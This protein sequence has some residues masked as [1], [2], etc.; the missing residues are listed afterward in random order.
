MFRKYWPVILIAAVLVLG[1]LFG[2]WASSNFR[3]CIN[4]QGQQPTT[5]HDEKKPPTA[6]VVPIPAPIWILSNCMGG[7][8]NENG[9]AITALATVLLTIVT[10]GFVWLGYLQFVTTRSQLRAY[11]SVIIGSA[12]EQD[13][14]KG[15]KFEGNPTLQNHGQTPAYR[16]RYVGKAD[17]I[18]DSLVNNY[19]FTVDVKDIISEAT[20]GPSETRILSGTVQNYVSDTD[21]PAIKAG[22]GSALWVWGTILYDDAFGRHHFVNFCQ[23][24]AWLSD[25]RVFGI[26]S[27]RFANSD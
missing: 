12:I 5:Q 8:A 6:L 15:L 27:P 25:G 7:F 20:I 23:R 26:Y 21:I 17:I 4:H 24:L 2:T 18:P 3:Y 16:V 13:R 19:Q 14:S 1:P 22:T 11:L 10:G 9:N